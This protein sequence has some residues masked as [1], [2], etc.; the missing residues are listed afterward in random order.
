MTCYDLV[1]T[2]EPR[3]VSSHAN[4]PRKPYDPSDLIDALKM[5]LG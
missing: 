4:L 3:K 2:L 5:P 1:L